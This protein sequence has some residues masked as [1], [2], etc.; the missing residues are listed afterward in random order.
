MLPNEV[1]ILKAIKENDG[2]DVQQLT[3]VTDIRGSYLRY[4]CNSMCRDGYLL[5]KDPEGYQATHK[6]RRAIFQAL[7]LN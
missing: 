2:L 5:R 6:G 3:H 4:I 1:A 7:Y